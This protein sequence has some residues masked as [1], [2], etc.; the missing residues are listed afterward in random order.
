M[1]KK[2]NKESDF[3][4]KKSSGKYVF[5]P[6]FVRGGY[7]FAVFIPIILSALVSMIMVLA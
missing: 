4:E 7:V 5:S 3:P 2:D 1:D 6:V